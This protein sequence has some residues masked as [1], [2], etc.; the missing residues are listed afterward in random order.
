MKAIKRQELTNNALDK[1]AIESDFPI[2]E[3]SQ[4]AEKE[5]WRKEINRPIYHIHK[6]W[7]KRLGSVFRAISLAALSPEK[8]HTWKNFYIRQDFRGKVVLDPFMGSGTTL[9]ESLKLGC[10][11]VGCDINPISTFLVR[12]ALTRVNECELRLTFA[13]LEQEVA[14]EIRQYYQTRDPETGEWIPVLYYFWVKTITTPDGESIPLFSNYVFAKNAYPKKKPKSQIICPNCWNI[15]EDRFDATHLPCPHC[16]AEFN[17]Q[18]GSTKGQYVNSRSGK[19][20]K[21]KDLIQAQKNPP[22]HRMYAMLALRANGEKI[23]LPA[24]DEDLALFRDAIKRLAVEDLP[25]PTMPVRPGHNTDQARGYNYLQWRDFFNARQLLCLGLLLRA[26]LNIENKT[27]QEQF[28]CLF[29]ST[30]EFNNLFCSFK[31]EG[32][33]AVRHMFSHHILKPERAPLEN[34]VWGTD[35]S[36]GTFATLFK[37]RLIPAKR[38]LDDPFEISIDVDLFGNSIGSNKITASQA[39]NASLVESWEAFS[40]QEQAALVLNGSSDNLPI[41]SEVIDVVITDPPYFDFVHYSE[42]SDFFFAWISPV[43]KERYSFFRRDNSSHFGEVQHNDPRL[44]TQQLSRVFTECHRTLKYDGLLIFSFHHSR[45]EGWAAICEAV[46]SSGFKVVA[47]HPV[48]AELKVASPKTSVTEP[49]SLDAILVCCKSEEDLNSYVDIISSRIKADRLE[50]VL[51]SGGI[52]LSEAD[53]FVILASQLLVE[54]SKKSMSFKS[55]NYLLQQQSITPN[56]PVAAE[57][58]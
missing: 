26:I 13:Q 33:G 7:A 3:V 58:I 16:Q 28:I 10:K 8:F 18:Q 55:M 50:K 45:S 5:S 49:I 12:Q 31:G 27:I 53:R 30:L 32:T 29:S 37:S 52:S 36:S 47:A 15:I 22:E 42:L 35:K 23:Y 25:I 39:I 9:G 41:P 51:E 14:T 2:L 20:Y 54:M 4:L 17:P 43:L 46:R 34:S 11:V 21:I 57:R 19:R 38:Y 44:F 1:K 48:Y 24:K 40:E 56:K 6:W